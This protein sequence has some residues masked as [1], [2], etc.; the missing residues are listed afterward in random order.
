M[1]VSDQAATL[2]CLGGEVPLTQ[3]SVPA[4]AIGAVQ[5]GGRPVAAEITAGG[6]L[7]RLP[8]PVSLPE[9]DILTVTLRK[10]GPFG[11]EDLPS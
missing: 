6:Q 11:P 10:I 7:A 8:E 9:G 2:R 1:T 5:V 3:V 4:G